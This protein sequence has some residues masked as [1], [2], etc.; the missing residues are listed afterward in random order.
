VRR[1]RLLLVPGLTELEWK[2][3]PELEE[4]ADVVSY[5]PPGVGAS[6]GEWTYE[7]TVARGLA[8]VDDKG[9]ESYVLAADGWATPVA[10][11]LIQARPAALRGFAIGHAA[12]S[13]RLAGDR[14]PLS[15]S[16]FSAFLRL[17]ETDS[18]GFARIALTQLTQDGF[19]EPLVRQ[20]LER[21]PVRVVVAHLRAM[22]QVTFDLEQLL[23]PLDVPLLFGKHEGCLL[24]TDEGFADAVAAFP[25][26]HTVSLPLTCCAS[27]I[28]AGALRELCDQIA[29]DD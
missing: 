16:V 14:S 19:D 13:G 17:V 8:A 6:S 15:G 7:G 28:F 29:A 27:P 5:D 26:A 1:P 12:L 18:E 2:I 24:Y 23:R 21:V 25:G 11:G 4:W 3:K 20:M 10:A 22:A 9:W